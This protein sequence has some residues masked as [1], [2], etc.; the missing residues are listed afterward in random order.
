MDTCFSS[1]AGCNGATCS[2][3]FAGLASLCLNVKSMRSKKS[4]NIMKA[5]QDFMR[6][7]GAPD[8]LNRDLA[9]EQKDED[10]IGL[11]RE[12]LVKDSHSERG[13]PNQN[14]AESQAMKV[15]KEGTQTT[16]TCTGCPKWCWPLVQE[17]IAAANNL[18]SSP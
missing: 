17:H 5:H 15:I 3:V 9:P 1:V 8:L 10:I 11:N 12:L 2:Q 18:T 13:N 7:E 16:L 4:G 14:P 6:F